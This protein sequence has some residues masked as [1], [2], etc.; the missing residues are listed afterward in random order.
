MDNRHLATR[1]IGRISG[2]ITLKKQHQDATISR[3]FTRLKRKELQNA[4]Q[5]SPAVVLLGPRQVGKNTL[6][7]VVA[8]PDGV[9][10]DLESP[11]DRNK[12]SNDIQPS[13]KWLIYPG[14]EC[15]PM[16]DGI[17]VMSLHGAMQALA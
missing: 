15:Y 13:R 8:L 7:L 11:E 3:M 17:E 5:R 9:Y 14:S 6:A 16:G 4:L 12:L 1:K 10:L 2:N